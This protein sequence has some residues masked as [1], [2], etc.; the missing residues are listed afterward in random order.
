[1]KAVHV[2]NGNAA[3]ASCLHLA[4]AVGEVDVRQAAFLVVVHGAVTF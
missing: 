4:V 1:M 3:T 2:L